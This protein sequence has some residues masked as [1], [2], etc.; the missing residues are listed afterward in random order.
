M[1]DPRL[2]FLVAGV[3]K[4]GTTALF[5]YLVE[6]PR[7]DMPS[8]KEAHFFDDETGVDW[9]APDY[10]PYHALFRPRRAGML[11][12]EATPIYVYWPNA[13]E[14][15][16]AYNP[17]IRLIVVL[18]DPVERA[19]SHWRMEY[20]RGAETEPFAWCIRQGRSRVASDPAAPGFH[21][22]HS[23]VERGFYGAQLR[24]M[25]SL[26][27]REQVLLLDAVDLHGKPAWILGN[28]CRFLDVPPLTDVGPKESHVGISVTGIQSITDED[29]QY[30]ADIYAHDQQLLANLR[31]NGPI[32]YTEV[33]P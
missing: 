4:G 26:F 7:I 5:D 17:A 9:N 30:L 2:S 18:R 21:R 10:G 11:R 15:I 13:L 3:Q 23:Y 19:W 14:R 33:R 20:A 29:R 28:V 27:P 32:G 31:D 25:F 24:R 6:H 1:D 12:G 22:V 8:I 16:A